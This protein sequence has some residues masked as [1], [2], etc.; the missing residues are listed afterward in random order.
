MAADPDGEG[1]HRKDSEKPVVAGFFVE[2]PA[3]WRYKNRCE[4]AT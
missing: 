1:Q 2:A 3:R 4:N